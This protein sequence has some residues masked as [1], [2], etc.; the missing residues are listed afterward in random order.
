MVAIAELRAEADALRD[1]LVAVR[2]DLHAHPE[3][4]F[5]EVRTAGIVAQRLGEL[6][7]EVQTGV[8]RTGV[9][10]LMEGAA[11]LEIVGSPSTAS[12]PDPRQVLLVRFDMDAL[13]IQESTD[14]PYSSVN[15]GV[16]HACGHDA[17]TAIGLTV[18]ELIAAHR[19]DWSGVLKLVFQPAEEIVAGAKAMIDDGVL[20]SPRPTRALSMHVDSMKPRGTV[21]MTDGPMMAAADSFTAVVRGRGAHGASPHQGADPVVAACQIVT[22]LQTIVSRNVAPWSK[23]WSRWGIYAA[24]R[25]RISFPKQ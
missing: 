3:L 17:H 15:P 18:A 11:A 9:V 24:A 7:Y 10:G 12:E 22:A 2:R 20:E 8:G 19:A 16:M 23:L 4:G 25:H 21:Y 14:L 1:Q 6:G 5:Q 13:P